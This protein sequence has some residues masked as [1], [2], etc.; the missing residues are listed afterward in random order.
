MSVAECVPNSN[1]VDLNFTSACASGVAQYRNLG[2][3]G[4]VTTDPQELRYA[5]VAQLG[6]NHID[7]V[8]TVTDTVYTYQ[9]AAPP[10]GCIGS[11]GFINV[12]ARE[13]TRWQNGA[14]VNSGSTERDPFDWEITFQFV[15]AGTY[16]PI[17]IPEMYISWYVPST[18]LPH[19]MHTLVRYAS[20]TLRAGSIWIPE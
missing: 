17:V 19:S 11:F 7:L 8:V 9:A 1:W 4:P 3:L 13:G 6:G 2:G 16:T 14:V 15:L 5:S 20:S 18:P 10:S 12:L